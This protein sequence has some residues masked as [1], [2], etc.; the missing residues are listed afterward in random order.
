MTSRVGHPC[1]NLT[2]ADQSRGAELAPRRALAVERAQVV[3][4][5][6]IDT[7]VAFTLIDIY[8]P[9]GKDSVRA[10]MCFWKILFQQSQTVP[11][12]L[13]NLALIILIWIYKA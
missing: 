1:R 7:R 4:A 2:D 6:P 3:P 13:V 8:N 9:E 11:E 10:A 12:C 5:G